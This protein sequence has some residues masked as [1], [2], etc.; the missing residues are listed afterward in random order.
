[1][2]KNGYFYRDL[3]LGMY[4]L[5]YVCFFFFEC[6]LII[7]ISFFFWVLEENLLVINNILKIVDFGLVREVVFM[8]FYIEYVFICW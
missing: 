7:C 4:V 6:F 5:L 2:Y 8:F 3:K 1:M